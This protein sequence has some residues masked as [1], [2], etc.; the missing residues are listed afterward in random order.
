MP[1]ASRRLRAAQTSVLGDDNRDL[2]SHAA[3]LEG[4][5]VQ[6][7]D[8]IEETATRLEQRMGVAEGRLDVAPAMKP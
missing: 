3:T 2:V 4:A 6:L 7:R 1:A 5:F 8:W